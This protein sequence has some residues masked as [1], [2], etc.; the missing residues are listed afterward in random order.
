MCVCE[1][2][3]QGCYLKTQGRGGTRDDCVASQHPNH[4]TQAIRL[5]QLDETKQYDEH[6]DKLLTDTHQ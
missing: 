6:V 1:Q 2:L 3:A 4:Y 5:W